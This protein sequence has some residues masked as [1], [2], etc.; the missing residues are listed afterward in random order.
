M[1]DRYTMWLES[2]GLVAVIVLLA[3]LAIRGLL[4]LFIGLSHLVAGAL[5]S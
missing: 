2:L 5:G 3:G 4:V 1:R